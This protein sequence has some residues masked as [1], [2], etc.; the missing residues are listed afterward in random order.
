MKADFIFNNTLNKEKIDLYEQDYII[1][2]VCNLL[3]IKPLLEE[4]IINVLEDHLKV[5]INYRKIVTFLHMYFSQDGDDLYHINNKQETAIKKVHKLEEYLNQKLDDIDKIFAKIGKYISLGRF[6]V[7]EV[8]PYIF[9]LDK[10]I[11]SKNNDYYLSNYFI[12]LINKDKYLIKID[13]DITNIDSDYFNLLLKDIFVNNVILKL[14]LSNAIYTVKD[15]FFSSIE[16]IYALLSLDLDNCLTALEQLQENNKIRFKDDLKKI[17]DSLNQIEYLVI[18]LRNGFNSETNTL[19]SIAKKFNVTRERIRQIENKAI[20]T[21]INKSQG[22]KIQIIAFFAIL[23]SSNEKRYVSFDKIENYFNDT[24]LAKYYV[25][26]VENS[27]LYIKYIPKLN[28]VYNSKLTSIEELTNEVINKCSPYVYEK[29]YNGLNSFEKAIILENYREYYSDFY[30]LKGYGQREL[31]SLLVDNLFIDGYRIYNKNDYELLSNTFKELYKTDE[32]PADRSIAATLERL[33]Y[34]Q[35]N[36]GTYKNRKYCLTL[37]E[38]FKDKIFNYILLN[39]PV[40]YYRSIFEEFKDELHEQGIDNYFYLKGLIDPY[41]P[42]DFSSTRDYILIGNTNLT[43]KD[44]MNSFI[45]SFSGVFTLNDLQNKFPGVKEYTFNNL[46]FNEIENGLIWLDT[47]RFIYLDKIALDNEDIITLKNLIDSLFVSLNSDTISSRMVYSKLIQTNQELLNKLKIVNDNFSL[48]SLLRTLFKDDFGFS[49]PL[50]SK[51]KEKTRSSYSMIASYVNTLDQFSFKTINDYTSKMNIRGLYSY[52]MFMEDM[53]DN[54]VQINI[55]T[56]C[57]KDKFV[58]SNIT[59]NEIK[60]DL[61]LMFSRF[62]TIDT[63]TFNGY[64]IF[65]KLQYNWNKYL[66]VGIIRTYLANEFEIINTSSKYDDNDFII[67]IFKNN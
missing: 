44:V 5:K 6:D 25:C 16:T 55:D 34:C 58:L 67:K 23:T 18:S 45:K 62:N 52:L 42:E 65:P 64:Q 27:D 31:I 26:L 24:L 60:E 10:K 47:K 1:Y 36:K 49:R 13:Q 15:L 2:F 61:N 30:L 7:E 63:K 35:I 41:L 21:I 66:L 22:L 20:N 50:I 3:S 11:E 8:I 17:Y 9:A 59:L 48:F 54:F 12:L 43:G 37:S 56:M 40:V 4:E 33:N 51:S 32:F 14:L 53:S 46:F 39:Q 38:E 19:E 57:K 29:D 28:I